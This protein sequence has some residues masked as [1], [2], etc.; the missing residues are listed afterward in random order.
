M[1]EKDKPAAAHR[2]V[3]PFSP[4]FLCLFAETNNKSIENYKYFSEAVRY[5]EIKLST[6]EG[7]H[8]K[9]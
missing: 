7:G 2:P 3:R 9:W 1:V 5:N 4:S 6:P 8:L